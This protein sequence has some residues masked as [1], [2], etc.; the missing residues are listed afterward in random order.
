[1]NYR[2]ISVLQL[3]MLL[4]T[5]TGLLNHVTIIPV[6]LNVAGKDAW[7]SVCFTAICSLLWLVL[8][9]RLIKA[10][11]GR[12]FVQW[13]WERWGGWA[14]LVLL[15]L[16]VALLGVGATTLKE[17]T[18]WTHVNY[19]PSTPV[20]VVASTF[21]LAC[22]ATARSG[23]KVLAIT[24][25]ILLPFI[26]VFGYFVAIGNF[27]HKDYLLLLPVMENGVGPVLTGMIYAGSGFCE[28]FFVLLLGHTVSGRVRYRT[29]LLLLVILVG[30]TLGPLTGAIA[31]FGTVEASKQRYPAYEQWR[32]LQLGRFIEHVDFFSIYQWL[33][34]AFVRISLAL[35]LI[36]DCL[37]VF[38]QNRRGTVLL[39][40]GAAMAAFALVPIP[41]SILFELQL[42]SFLP[43]HLAIFA[44]ISL[45]VSIAWLFFHRHGG[46]QP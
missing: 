42:T 23:I 27:P 43:A 41:D 35:W 31:E 15:P 4:I 22:L 39:V 26:V 37:S 20:V 44:G 29:L 18:D 9:H 14:W 10:T 11:D 6:L 30:L 21:V 19:L 1:M 34:G 5:G 17:T 13:L 38:C 40:S 2:M 12:P 33:S 3:G 7:L 45:I 32:I 8:L 24:N 28:L 25:G 46:I 16:L 36:A